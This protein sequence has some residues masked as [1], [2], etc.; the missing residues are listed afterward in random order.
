MPSHVD[1]A[2]ICGFIIF[3]MAVIVQV[4]KVVSLHANDVQDTM[5]VLRWLSFDGNKNSFFWR[6]NKIKVLYTD[7]G[8]V[9]KLPKACLHCQNKSMTIVWPRR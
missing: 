8:V 1:T 3:V 7:L 4:F 5:Q 6:E 9:V 2:E